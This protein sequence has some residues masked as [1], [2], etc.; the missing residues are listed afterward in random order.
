M[1]DEVGLMSVRIQSW[2]PFPIQVWPNGRQWLARHMDAARLK[3][4]R[5]DNCFTRAST[6]RF[7]LGLE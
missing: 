7:R 4:V 3:Y 1:D 5:Q 2:F 6:H